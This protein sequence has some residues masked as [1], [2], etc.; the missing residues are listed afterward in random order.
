LFKNLWN[1]RNSLGP[2]IYPLCYNCLESLFHE[3]R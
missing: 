2:F 1:I 3:F